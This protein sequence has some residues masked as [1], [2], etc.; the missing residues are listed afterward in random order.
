MKHLRERSN[1]RGSTETL[2]SLIPIAT[3][4]RIFASLYWAQAVLIPVA[5]AGFTD[6]FVESG[7]RR[8]G[9]DS[10][11]DEFPSVISGRSCEI[12]TPVRNPLD[13][14]LLPIWRSG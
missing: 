5:L 1:L 11:V 3:F 8:P 6:L 12:F 7:S 9:A 4:I 10:S 2:P 13:R 14:S